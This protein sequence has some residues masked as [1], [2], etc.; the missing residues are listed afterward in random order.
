ML[1]LNRQW[2]WKGWGLLLAGAFL[3][4]SQAGP[5]LSGMTLVLLAAGFWT[6]LRTTGM[7]AGAS[8][9]AAAGF[10]WAGF[11]REWWVAA[12]VTFGLIPLILQ[13]KGR[14]WRR[15]ARATE[16]TQRK[17]RGQLADME[18]GKADLL[19]S[20]HEQEE[21]ISRISDLYGLSKRFL[22]TLEEEQALR[23]TEEALLKDLPQMEAGSRERFLSEVC[24]MVKKGEVSMDS[25]V[26]ALPAGSSSLNA[27]EKGGI[28]IGQLA[29][30]LQRVSLYHQV[31]QSAIH[32][33]LTGL[34]V[35]RHF[36]ERLE[37]E[38][39]R[40]GR[41]G[42]PLSFL[43]VDLDHFKQIN[44]TYGHLVGDQVLREVA[45]L[46]QRSV[47]EADLIGRY[48][49][50]EFGVV[51]PEA[52]RALGIQIAE[53]IRLTVG[54]HSLRVFDETLSVTVSV[55]AALFPEDGSTADQIVEQADRAMYSAK[56]Q[57]RN[58]T[59]WVHS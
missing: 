16:E 54:G 55:G 39:S 41:R 42:T 12:A 52:D 7:V 28:V 29:L 15:S 59:V 56:A 6:G 46:I 34:L 38:I 9:L 53:R 3:A 50:E 58:R 25:L 36:R 14:E 30:G 40:A 27:W 32:D 47:R 22:A 31:Q 51:L 26:S 21:A 23:V 11:A 44:D 57:G 20:V 49:G 8:A 4:R 13:E 5:W 10:G 37:E 19:R 43:M 24:S 48:G 2:I 45:G 35:R 33:G 18:R 17:L 1:R